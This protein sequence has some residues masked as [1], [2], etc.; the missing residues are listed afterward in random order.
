V[1]SYG[2]GKK[3]CAIAP[4]AR[5][6]NLQFHQGAALDDGSGLMEGSGRSMR[7]VRIQSEADLTKSLR[8]LIRAAA[9][10]AG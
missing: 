10:N 8:R 2:H 1:I 7:H 9:K 3:F 5:W 4:H 6:V